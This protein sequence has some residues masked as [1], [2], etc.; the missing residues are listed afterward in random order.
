MTRHA[1]LTLLRT[2]LVAHR[3]GSMTAAADELGLS[4]PGV[5]AQ[6]RA[7]EQARGTALFG[8]HARGLTATA[9]GDE[10][11]A[12]IG[13]HLDALLGA[14]DPDP[15]TDPYARTVLLGGPPELTDLRV[16]PALAGLFARGLRVRVT[17]GH[18]DALLGDVGRGSLDL[19]V[20]TVRPRGRKVE[21]VPIADE[22]FVLVAA[23]RLAAAIEQGSVAADPRSALGPLPLVAYS[24]GLPVIRR[25]WRHVFGQPPP[26]RPPAVLVCDLRAVAAAAAADAGYTV[27]PRY[28]AAD[29]LAAGELVVLHEP[30]DPPINTFHLMWP[31]HATA[32]PAV[33]A[34]R[35]ALR[36]AARA[37]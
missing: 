17:T 16:L 8:R 13:P 7:L 24:E 22:E 37:W 33:D 31:A 19:A 32:H 11:A 23:P 34:V 26:G 25:Y 27:L 10:L 29:R 36:T 14:L 18:A 3:T 28:L 12:R 1:D 35:E 5:T 4:Q 15:A 2:F 21:S 9:A 30:E 20:S 6:I